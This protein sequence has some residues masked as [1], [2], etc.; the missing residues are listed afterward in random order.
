MPASL[1]T[2]FAAG[3]AATIAV[4]TKT[5]ANVRTDIRIGSVGFSNNLEKMLEKCRTTA[6]ASP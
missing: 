5:G 2:D 3:R 4:T 6:K 1:F